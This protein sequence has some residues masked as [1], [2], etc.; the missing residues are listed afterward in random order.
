[1]RPP[2][3][4]DDERLIRTLIR[5]VLGEE[6]YGI[7]GAANG[8]EALQYLADHEP[9]LIILDLDM[10]VMDG[11]RCYRQF[12]AEGVCIPV[13]ILSA[14]NAVKVARDLGAQAGMAKPFDIAALI[15]V[16][17]ELVSVGR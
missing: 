6:G 14:S 9:D 7:A 5:E 1:M 12:R 11:A 17:D 8:E 15:H 4:V 2:L 10:P 13:L 3:I 16:V